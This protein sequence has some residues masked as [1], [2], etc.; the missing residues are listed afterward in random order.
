MSTSTSESASARTGYHH[1]DLRRTLLLTARELV[2]TSGAD[3]ISLREVARH[4]GVS[5]GAAYRHFVDKNDLLRE[6]AVLAF[7]ELETDLIAAR[8]ASA[9]DDGLRELGR[10]YL[11]FAFAHAA[12]FRFMFRRELCMPPGEPDPLQVASLRAEA[13]VTDVIRRAQ[14]SGFLAPADPL[15]LT[16]SYWAVVH[17]MT[18]IM[19]E[20]PAFKSIDVEHAVP[21]LDHAV[22]DLTEGLR[23][24]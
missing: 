22:G 5:H 1:G 8:D 15:D 10:V 2:R 19:L 4:A 9:P 11:R 6:I 23:A 21:L 7:E 3:Q 20:T 13:V 17:G 24:R 14:T 18:T 12:E 16:L